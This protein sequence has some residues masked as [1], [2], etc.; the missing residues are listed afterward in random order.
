MWLEQMRWL[1]LVFSLQAFCFAQMV[2]Y[3]RVDPFGLSDDFRPINK[4]TK[5]FTKYINGHHW[6]QD[7]TIA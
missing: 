4:F 7:K 1:E 3:V 6:D 2:S 5:V